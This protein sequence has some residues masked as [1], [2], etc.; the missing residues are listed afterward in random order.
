ML[1]LIWVCTVCYDE[2]SMIPTHCLH[3]SIF[4]KIDLSA[5]VHHFPKME[6]LLICSMHY[7]K[8]LSLRSCEPKMSLRGGVGG[9]GIYHY[10]IIF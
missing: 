10:N 3:M 8:L 6:I 4:S 1:H 9:G 5:M 7:S 2:S